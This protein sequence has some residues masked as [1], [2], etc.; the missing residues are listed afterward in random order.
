MTEAVN[1]L[2][3]ALSELIPRLL[4]AAAV[5]IGALLAALVVQRFATR[6][7]RRAGLDDLFER[8]GASGTLWRLGYG[9]GP[10]RLISTVLFWAVL[11]TGLA[12][13]VG[14]LGLASVGT[15]LEGIVN[16]SGRALVAISIMIG[17]IMSAGWLAE[18]AARESERAGLRGSESFRRAVFATILAFAALIAASQLGLETSLLVLITAIA[19]ATAGLVSA[20]ALGYGLAPLSGNIAAGRYVREGVEEGDLISVGGVEGT[21]EEIGHASVTLRSEDGYLYRIPNSTLLENVVR[22]RA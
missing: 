18:L 16:L 15:T 17:G 11:L 6:L 1:D 7:L 2:T 14:V 19:L 4:G 9:E 10:S 21:V 20:L 13:S 8:S 12:G 22:K 3:A 5:L